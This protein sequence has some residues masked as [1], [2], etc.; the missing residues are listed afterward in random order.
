MAF[1]DIMDSYREAF[2]I[3]GE[4]VKCDTCGVEFDGLTAAH[5][6]HRKCDCPGC[7]ELHDYPQCDRCY[8]QEYYATHDQA[9]DELLECETD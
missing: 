5:Y 4:T 9:T 8:W 7:E 2:D 6:V 3:H 1:E